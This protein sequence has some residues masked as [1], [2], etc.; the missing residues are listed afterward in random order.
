[1]A[2]PP[3]ELARKLSLIRSASLALVSGGNPQLI[4]ESLTRRLAR[5][6]AAQPK[7]SSRY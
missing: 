7:N 2:I 6:T 1:M 5:K 4:L 3:A